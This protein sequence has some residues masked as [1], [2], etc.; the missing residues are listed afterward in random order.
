MRLVSAA[1]ALLD[2]AYCRP[3]VKEETEI[4]ELP[5]VVIQLTQPKI[6]QRW[7]PFQASFV[8]YTRCRTV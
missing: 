6:S 3:A 8:G 7:Q 5:P 1:N 2:R 4:V